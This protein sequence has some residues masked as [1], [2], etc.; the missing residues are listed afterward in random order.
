[1]IATIAEAREPSLSRSI[2][3]LTPFSEPLYADGTANR[4]TAK[5]VAT[6]ILT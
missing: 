1:V 4:V 3:V 5:T 6:D 2:A